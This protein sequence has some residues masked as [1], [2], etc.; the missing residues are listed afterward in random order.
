MNK[1]KEVYHQNPLIE[2]NFAK[3]V[4]SPESEEY[5]FAVAKEGNNIKIIYHLVKEPKFTR[6]LA[7]V[8]IYSFRFIT[9]KNSITHVHWTRLSNFRSGWSA[10]L[11]DTRYWPSR[12]QGK[13]RSLSPI[14]YIWRLKTDPL[15]EHLDFCSCKENLIDMDCKINF[16][17][18]LNLMLYK[19]II[20]PIMQFSYLLPLLLGLAICYHPQANLV[21]PEGLID[22]EYTSDHKYLVAL[23][24]KSLNIYNGI[25]ASLIQ[26]F[27]V[28]EGVTALAVSPNG[29]SFAVAAEEGID[30]YKVT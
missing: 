1:L 12:T 18:N 10:P 3:L 29:H 19:S 28:E 21:L 26:N 27:P 23:G 2:K 14:K 5:P 8:D 24:A 20:I 22:M 4:P 7:N 6:G 15:Y 11:M 13:T 25:T 16:T 9:Q 30:F 17:N